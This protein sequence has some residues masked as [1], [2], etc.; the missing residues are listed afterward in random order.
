MKKLTVRFSL[1][2][3]LVTMILATV[4]TVHAREIAKQLTVNNKLKEFL[5]STAID[6]METYKED[7]LQVYKIH[8]INSDKYYKLVLN[9]SN[10]VEW[11]GMAKGG[12]F[13]KIDVGLKDKMNTIDDNEKLPV[14][15][16]LTFD[17]TSINKKLSAIKSQYFTDSGIK[18]N[19]T[20]EQIASAK[21][22]KK[23]FTKEL[24][25]NYNNLG[26]TYEFLAYS[27]YS[28]FIFLNLTKNEVNELVN[29]SKVFSM[30]LFPKM[31]PEKIEINSIAIAAAINNNPIFSTRTNEVKN[32]GLTGS[33]IRIGQI[34]SSN[35]NTSNAY[36]TGKTIIKRTTDCYI[37]VDGVWHATEIAGILV[38][39]TGVAP[40]AT[41]YSACYSGTSVSSFASG[42]NWLISQNVDIINMSAWID[43]TGSYNTMDRWIDAITYMNDILFVKS[44]GN[45][46]SNQNPQNTITSPGI[47]F[48]AITVGNIVYN[49]ASYMT[50]ATSSREPSSRYNTYGFQQQGN[51]PEL[52]APGTDVNY[53][54]AYGGLVTGTSMSAPV[55][56]GAAALLMQSTPSTRFNFNSIKAALYASSRHMDNYANSF[57]T[58]SEGWGKIYTTYNNQVG[59][60]ILDTKAA[61]DLLR[62]NQFRNESIIG[63]V[64]DTY[65]YNNT[66][67]NGYSI[68]VAITWSKPNTASSYNN[69]EDYGTNRVSDLDLHILGPS[70]QKIAKS[71]S[72]YDNVEFVYFTTAQGYGNYKFKVIN[73]ATFGNAVPIDFSIA[74]W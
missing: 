13:S 18:G 60:G 61:Y 74:W 59:M 26:G 1:S 54:D 4:Y 71:R 43:Q 53:T 46:G 12:Y 58:N 51:K 33:G 69:I 73:W 28:P 36:L 50:A 66:L 44:S 23:E 68:T 47:A 19:L 21:A 25:S 15:V 62:W 9:S 45:T 8:D 42:I 2:I 24:M 65:I 57:V 34:E 20:E 41:L 40:G 31:E 22:I 16:E 3:V 27:D 17:Y 49:G 37:G 38:G 52:V 48:N 55:L 39:D 5:N 67:G 32:A 64:D 14:I 10:R 56:S 29:N 35:P 11:Y 70:D 7:E 63:G 6:V 30:G 72:S